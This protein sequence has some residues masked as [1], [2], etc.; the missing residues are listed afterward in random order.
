VTF[1]NIQVSTTTSG[2]GTVVLGNITP[3]QSGGENILS[4]NYTGLAGPGQTA[5]IAWTYNV[6]GNLLNDAFLSLA[7]TDSPTALSTVSETLSNGV[8]LSL[9]GAGSTSTT[10]AAIGSLSVIKDQANVGN[11]GTAIASILQ[12]GFSVVPLP[13]AL[14]MFLGGLGGLWALMRRRKERS[15]A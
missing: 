5:D 2:G 14:P 11:S 1:F 7:A 12:N 8:T 6:S 13:G 9:L 3:I 15:I 4:L 10:F